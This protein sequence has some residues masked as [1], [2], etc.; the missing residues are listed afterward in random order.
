[1]KKIMMMGASLL[2]GGVALAQNAGIT[3]NADRSLGDV[4][5]Y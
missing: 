2:L 5:P 3:I 1:M 4:S